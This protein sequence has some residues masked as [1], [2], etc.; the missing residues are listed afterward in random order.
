MVLWVDKIRGP[1]AILDSI[2]MNMIGYN[3]KLYLKLKRKVIKIT[4]KFIIISPTLN[5]TNNLEH[6]TLCK[7]IA[8]W[9]E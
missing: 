9:D 7:E 5:N 2:R 4:H 3:W 8:Y 6:I 1:V